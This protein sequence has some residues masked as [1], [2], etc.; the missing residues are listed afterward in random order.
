MVEVDSHAFN[1]GS[2]WREWSA[3]RR[4]RCVCLGWGENPGTFWVG[5][6]ARVVVWKP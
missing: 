6:W 1:V 4:G 3:S 5:G 2:R